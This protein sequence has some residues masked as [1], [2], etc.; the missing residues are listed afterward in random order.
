MA[1]F[2]HLKI[3]LKELLENIDVSLGEP[4]VL[5]ALDGISKLFETLTEIREPKAFLTC[6]SCLVDLD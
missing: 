5:S 1:K 6:E 3:V 4:R 2:C